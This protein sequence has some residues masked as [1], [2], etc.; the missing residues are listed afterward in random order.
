MRQEGTRPTALTQQQP[1]SPWRQER[2]LADE[3]VAELQP[4]RQL[5]RGLDD[6]IEPPEG[7]NDV[8]GER[9]AKEVVEER[10][11]AVDVRDVE[12]MPVRA[13]DGCFFWGR[14]ALYLSLI[15]I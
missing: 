3:R 8:A 13:A 2:P 14:G 5:R 12:V 1:T 4:Q 7:L 15:H 6:G 11:E 9:G 10:G